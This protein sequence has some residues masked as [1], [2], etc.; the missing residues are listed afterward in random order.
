MR[1]IVFDKVE[2]K[3]EGVFEAR[4]VCELGAKSALPTYA[5]AFYYQG[6]AEVTIIGYDDR[7]LK[8]VVREFFFSAQHLTEERAKVM[9]SSVVEC[10]FIDE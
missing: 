10:C 7:G 8:L 6:K 1:Y 2:S 4:G 5:L 9:I 3:I